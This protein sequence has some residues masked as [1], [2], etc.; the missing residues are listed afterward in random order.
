MTTE[1]IVRSPSALDAY[2]NANDIKT[3]A[4]RIKVCLPGGDRLQESDVLA[5]AQLSLAY[6]LNPFNGE[7]W[8]IVDKHGNSRGTM[9][10]IKGL[11]KAARKQANYWTEFQILNTQE[12]EDLAVP[13]DA[14]GYRCLVYRTDILRQAAEAVKMMRDAGME[15]AFERYAYQPTGGIGYCHPA[16]PTK[17]K[18]DQCARKRA[19]ADALKQ[20]F[21]LPF[22][23]DGNGGDAVGYIDAEYHMMNPDTHLETPAEPEDDPFATA[24]PRTRQDGKCPVCHASGNAHAPWCKPAVAGVDGERVDTRQQKPTAAPAPAPAPTSPA[25]PDA[26][27]A[28]TE[29]ASPPAAGSSP[30]P[31]GDSTPAPTTPAQGPGQAEASAPDAQDGDDPATD[32]PLRPEAVRRIVRWKSGWQRNGGQDFTVRLLDGEPIAKR[33]VNAL[34]GLLTDSVKAKGMTQ[35]DLDQARA[36]V[37]TYL[38]EVPAVD[39]LYDRE[40]LA[41]IAWLAADPADPRHLNDY[42]LIE[43]DSVLNWVDYEEY[44]EEAAAESA[45]ERE[46]DDSFTDEPS[47]GPDAPGNHTKGGALETDELPF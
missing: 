5:L 6:N 38:V 30:R 23:T 2:G 32:R 31:G 17:M 7:V 3:M 27:P 45:A 11:R 43:A 8:L 1:Q 20:A 46:A 21:D 18:P 42:A 28:A 22:A 34:L 33:R 35:D 37:L 41:L 10:G 25:A 44:Q 9:V 39:D 36:A 13:A 4:R 12:K 14:I 40:A 47:P 24:P 26:S 29:T 16:E 15:N 19:E